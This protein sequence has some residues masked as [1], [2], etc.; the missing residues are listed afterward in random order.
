MDI[1]TLFGLSAAVM[2]LS[3]A[4]ISADAS[5]L[6]A[7]M[8]YETKKAELRYTS[9]L[10][11]P[12]YINIV[13][14]KS[15][16]DSPQ[17]TDYL[18]ITEGL[19]AQNG[20]I[21]MTVDIGDDIESGTYEFFA[22]GGGYDAENAKAQAQTVILGKNDIDEALKEVN[23]APEKGIANLI[24]TKLSTAL[25][26]AGDADN[27]WRDSY[28]CGERALNGGF[29]N[30]QQVKNAWTFAGL[31][32]A[33]KEKNPA[34]IPAYLEENNDIAGFDLQNADYISEQEETCRIIQN[35]CK[36]IGRI[37][38]HSDMTAA[39]PEAVALAKINKS[40]IEKKS[41][42]IT[43]YAD[44]LGVTDLM[45]EYKKLD[46]LKAARQ[47]DG[48]KFNSASEF[49]SKLSEVIQK[50]KNSD[51]TGT[52]PSGGGNGGGGGG[53]TSGRPSMNVGVNTDNNT[54]PEELFGDMNSGHW[55]YPSVKALKTMN[56][57]DGYED[58]SFK[59]EKYVTREEFVKLIAL[60][61]EISDGTGECNFDDIAPD[62]WCCGYIAA[63]TRDG[64]VNGIEENIFGRGLNIK[65]QDAAVMLDRAIIKYKSADSSNKPDAD[66]S[67][68]AEISDYAY[69]SI[70]RLS[71]ANI[72]N[73][74]DGAFAPSKP[75]SRAQAAKMIYECMKYQSNGGID[76]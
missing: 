33:V 16:I 47:L 57:I 6:T 26:I 1:K 75:V 2:A 65:R 48:I 61:F 32:K 31:V 56:I 67:D 10:E 34:D 76:K 5:E 71:E 41:E 20:S 53:S 37:K 3:A 13:M 52:K 12:S 36:S 66:F 15:G 55:A 40:S 59:P 70:G 24:Y 73:G 29:K 22:R 63:V 42:Y 39:F 17:Y 60:A 49:R 8:N 14:T 58:G 19:C 50:L 25:Q 27:S 18:R 11:Y 43:K 54:P 7:S 35:M 30:L 9:T 23:A 28:I 4:G 44:I 46:S 74:I 72:I 68:K 69:E 21:L 64:I 45:T 51:N 62:D 38:N